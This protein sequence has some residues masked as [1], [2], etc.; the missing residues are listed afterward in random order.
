MNFSIRKKFFLIALIGLI[1]IFFMVFLASGVSKDSL[2]KIQNVFL[3][4]Q[5][6]HKIEEDFIYPLF[7]LREV[8][9]S[10]VMAPNENFR[11]NIRQNLSPLI[12]ILDK[13]FLSLNNAELEK[14]WQNYKKLVLLTD[15]Y[16]QKDF[17]EGAFSNANRVER[18]QFYILLGKLTTLQNN[19]LKQSHDTFKNI[20]EDFLKNEK[21]ILISSFFVILFSLLLFFIIANNIVRAIDTLQNGLKKFFDLLGRKID[22]NT[23]I[24]IKLNNKDEFYQMANMINKNVE[25]ARKRL[26]KDLQLIKNA[27]SVVNELK[28]GHLHRR[29]DVD[30]SL[31]ELN[32]LKLVLNQMLDNLEDRI[33][34]EIKQ[35]TQKEQLLVQ[36]SKLATMGE[37]IGNIAHQWRQPLGEVNSILMRIAVKKEHDDLSDEEFENALNECDK[38]LLHMSKTISDF[39]NFFKPS[40]EKT[41][42]SIKKACEE[43]SFIISSS[44]K[45]NHIDFILNIEQDAKILGYPREF[46]QTIL[47]LLSNAKD[48]LIERDIKNPFIKLTIKSGKKFALIQVEDNAGGIKEEHIER[49]F[50]PYF[51]TKHAKQ[52]TGIGLYMSKTIIEENMNGFLNVKNR[53]NGALFTIKLKY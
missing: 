45:H 36:Q 46:S 13:N 24:K 8:S 48:V 7:S 15:T 20:Q 16:I 40:K 5:E 52:G 11:E 14:I 25:I 53:E 23:D 27:T 50:E 47:N 41:R 12:E 26:Q 33:K 17:E 30:K 21:F 34:D 22:I 35:R 51:T 4:S 37:M 49:I 44:L 2:K 19:K 18:K 29:F 3:S 28:I 9:L 38:I 42:F 1:S 6:V 31:D 43:A 10:L 39:Q 32:E